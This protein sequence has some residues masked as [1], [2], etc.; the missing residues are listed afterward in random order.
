MGRPTESWAA[1]CPDSDRGPFPG[2]T[3][4][5]QED[6]QAFGI[7][8]QRKTV[9]IPVVP[10]TRGQGVCPGEFEVTQKGPSGRSM[11]FSTSGEFRPFQSICLPRSA[12]SSGWC[13]PDRESREK[14]V[15]SPLKAARPQAPGR[16]TPRSP[17]RAIRPPGRSGS[18][19]ASGAGRRRRGRRR[20]LPRWWPA[21]ARPRMRCRRNA[22]GR[23]HCRNFR[24]RSPYTH[25]GPG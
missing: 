2:P 20:P 24:R 8:G 23:I 15:W 22:T 21:R 10:A 5:P 11:G 12:P 3:R 13:F 19:G 14:P 25:S 1:R 9:V 7:Q 6:D 18:P 4:S 16:V 17:R